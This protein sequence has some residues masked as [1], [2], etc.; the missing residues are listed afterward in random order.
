MFNSDPRTTLRRNRVYVVALN[1]GGIDTEVGPFYTESM[2][3]WNSNR[4]GWNAYYDEF[5]G[6]NNTFSQ[7]QV[8]IR[9]ILSKLRGMSL[10]EATRQTFATNL[11][12]YKCHDQAELAKYPPELIDCWKYH[13][14]FLEIVRPGIV[15]CVGDGPASS[16]AEFHKRLGKDAK[17]E[18]EKVSQRRYVRGFKTEDK[19]VLGIPHLS[20]PYA[21]I[22]KILWGLD[23]VREKL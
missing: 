23:K 15:L 16:F 20:R 3:S 2:A 11:Y 18:D 5:W 21:G 7:H 12:F 9:E 13:E 4:L 22:G 17:I 8:N 19:V 14:K 10:E 6:R 1:P